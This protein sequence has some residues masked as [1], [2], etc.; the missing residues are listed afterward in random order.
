MNEKVG[1]MRKL[2]NLN[3][4]DV[5]GYVFI[6]QLMPIIVIPCMKCLFTPM[7]GWNPSRK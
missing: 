3:T 7:K 2:K 1:N 4:L 6:L 5:C